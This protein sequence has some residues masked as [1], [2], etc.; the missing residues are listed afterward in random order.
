MRIIPLSECAFTIDKT[1]EFIP[2]DLATDDLQARATG[3]L[4]VEI[5]P[6]L[7]VPDRAVLLL[8]TGLGFDEEFVTMSHQ[9]G[10]RSG[11]QP[12]PILMDLN[13]FWHPNTHLFVRSA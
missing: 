6:F 13:L 3:S 11:S 2:F 8:A 5:Q 10:N 4:L 12:Q 1:K 7:I 9:L